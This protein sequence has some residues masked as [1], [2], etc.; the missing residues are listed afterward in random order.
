MRS[1]N[2]RDYIFGKK[3]IKVFKLSTRM[4][5]TSLGQRVKFQI[6]TF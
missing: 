2:T 5:D 1:K 6:I 3:I 4:K